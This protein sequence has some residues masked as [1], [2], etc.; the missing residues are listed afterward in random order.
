VVEL[1]AR[2]RAL[3]LVVGSSRARGE[4]GGK[5]AVSINV[6]CQLDSML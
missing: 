3:E 5:A 1:S 6:Y 4:K 2:E